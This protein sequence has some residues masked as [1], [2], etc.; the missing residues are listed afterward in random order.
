MIANVS[1]V[2]PSLTI[3]SSKS[4][5]VWSNTLSIAFLIYFSSLKAVKMIETSTIIFNLNLH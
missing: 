2:D 3:I 4:E 1:S 5:N